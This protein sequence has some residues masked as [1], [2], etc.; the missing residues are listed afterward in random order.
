MK[1][2]QTVQDHTKI[3]SDSSIPQNRNYTEV[4]FFPYDFGVTVIRHQIADAMVLA[5]ALMRDIH[6]PDS[7]QNSG[8][9]K[10]NV[11]HS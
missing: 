2:A 4:R 9:S 6:P 7:V 11:S 10:G 3:S 5:S 1:L 8:L